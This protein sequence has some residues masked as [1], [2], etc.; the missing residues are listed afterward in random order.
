MHKS[1]IPSISL[2]RSFDGHEFDSQVSRYKKVD[3]K[4]PLSEITNAVIS[5]PSVPDIDSMMTT[6]AVFNSNVN[7][8]NT[9]LMN[10]YYY[11]DP[12]V[13][14]EVKRRE[15]KVL[16]DIHHFKKS[17]EEIEQDMKT[18]QGE[19][20]PG[21][22]YELG[23]KATLYK[24]LRVETTHMTTRLDMLNNKCE[25]IRANNELA[26]NNLTLQ[27][28]LEVQNLEA[29]LDQ[30]INAVR[31]EWELK[32]LSLEKFKPDEALVKEI[33]HLKIER[34]QLQKKWNE[35]HSMNEE[36]R[37]N[38][39]KKLEKALQEF[40]DKKSMF[41]GQLMT[42]QSVLLKEKQEWELQV[43]EMHNTL[44]EQKQEKEKLR[45]EI[46]TLEFEL[47][48]HE[49][50]IQ[51]LSTKL[52]KLEE[53]L[54]L[55]RSETADVKQ[56]AIQS[57]AEYNALYDK[58]E[59][60]QISRRRIENTIEELHG[61]IRCYA[62]VDDTAISYSVNYASKTIKTG[63]SRQYSFNR[64]IPKEIMPLQDLFRQ[65]CQAYMDMCLQNHSNS[66]IISLQHEKNPLIHEI[67][68]TWI[69]EQKHDHV[70]FQCVLLSE[71]SPSSDMLASDVLS[72]DRDSD[73]EIKVTVHD[74]SVFFESKK[75]TVFSGAS[76]DELLGKLKQ[77]DKDDGVII[78]K[79][80][81][82]HDKHSFSDVHFVELTS[83]SYKCLKAAISTTATITETASPISIILRSL[84]THTKSL[85]LL[86]L[87]HEDEHLLDLSHQIGQQKQHA[88]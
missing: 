45:Q 59:E 50:S 88:C 20:I 43:K 82:W 32:L 24:D 29:E 72:T 74:K 55:N 3:N 5:A 36:K 77:D 42:K 85:L 49:L 2:K 10:K 14:E 16:K 27:Q 79:F 60:A 21:L 78:L 51:P 19:T 46:Q 40:K 12:R 61:K 26:L 23:K 86:T 37:K 75:V 80:K 17:I 53:Q 63:E 83:P 6:K 9:R 13:I 8:P 69:L 31:E 58:M 34:N 35:I 70:D 44:E 73:S 41:L 68:I 30:K 71:N 47:K 67:I 54:D 15:R 65:E 28:Q 64:V 62:Y 84:L 56:Q 7:N 48:S 1:R 66:S 11:G 52:H 33:E 57:E 87:T 76:A 39:E 4:D 81:I 22:R 38:H 25:V 18:M